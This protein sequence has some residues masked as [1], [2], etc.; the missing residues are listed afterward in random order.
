MSQC[1][2]VNRILVDLC[3]FNPVYFSHLTFL[4]TPRFLVEGDGLSL[5]QYFYHA[6]TIVSSGNASTLTMVPYSTESKGSRPGE[7]VTDFHLNEH[8]CTVN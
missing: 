7:V 1:N 6:T 2:A 4:D 3:H 5:Q 8:G